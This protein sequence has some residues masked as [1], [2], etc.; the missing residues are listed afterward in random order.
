MPLPLDPRF[1]LGFTDSSATSC[2]RTKFLFRG[3]FE[4]VYFLA[5]SI[6]PR[7]L[8]T[9]VS[10]VHAVGEISWPINSEVILRDVPFGPVIRRFAEPD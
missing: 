9:L 10:Y 1:C 8:S 5:H 2:G 3:Q 7:P 6:L 4:L